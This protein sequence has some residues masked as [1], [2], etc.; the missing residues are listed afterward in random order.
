MII[1]MARP[2]KETPILTGEDAKHFVKEMKRVEAI[3]PEV[4]AAYW[5]K[6]ERE[7]QEISRRISI[8]I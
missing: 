6:L 4:R 3:S 8:C 2:I 7:F 5:E 1:I